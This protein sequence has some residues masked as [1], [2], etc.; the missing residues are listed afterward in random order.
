M[1]SLSV[2]I[3]GLPNAGKS[4]LF[5]ALASRRLA[6]TA[7]RPFTTIK[8]HEAVVPVPDDNLEKLARIIKSDQSNPP[9][10]VPASITFIDIAGLV[11]GAH[12]GEGLGNQFLAKIREV[13]AIVHVARAFFDPFVTH[14]HQTHEPGTLE[15]ILE[16]IEI[17]SLELQIANIVKP[18]IYVL[19]FD[20]KRL[21]SDEAKRYEAVVSQ[22]FNGLTVSICAKLEEEL[23][24]FES[25]EREKY[26]NQIGVSESGIEKLVILAYKIL[27]LI[28]FYT[29]KGGKEI[30]AWNLKE[31]ESVLKAA[32]K[33]HSDFAKNFIKAEVISVEDLLS[34]AI[35]KESHEDLWKL[36]KENGLI[37]LEGKDY[38]VKNK[39]VIEFKISA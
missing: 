25:V 37:R 19:N 16:D 8:P 22:H 17:V 20:E 14:Q 39:D 29:I 26:L 12:K 34:L 27:G 33:V 28:T 9:E 3:V 32:E 2:G 31:G 1:S 5:N 10:I 4:T 24:D 15:Q 11:R 36:A 13:D 30:H 18:Q 38:I 7:P 35:T 23:I 21:F 6:E